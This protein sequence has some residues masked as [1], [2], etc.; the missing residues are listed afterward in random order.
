M[1]KIICPFL[2]IVLLLKLFI[3]K[4]ENISKIL[5]KYFILCFINH[6]LCLIILYNVLPKLSLFKIMLHPI[7]YLLFS[8]GIGLL[9]ALIY[10]IPNIKIKVEP[11]KSKKEQKSKKIRI[12]FHI[13][14][15]IIFSLIIIGTSYIKIF[16]GNETIDE[17]IFYLNNGAGNGDMGIYWLVIKTCF[18]FFL[19]LLFIMISL[20]YNIL[21]NYK[22]ILYTKKRGFKIYPI[23]FLRNHKIISTTFFCML[24]LIIAFFNLNLNNYYK[25]ALTKSTFIEEHYIMNP[26][27]VVFQEKRNLIFIIVESLET[28]MFTKEQGG[29][30]NY[31]IIPELY[32]L[33]NEEGSIYFS[34]TENTGGMSSQSAGSWTTAAIVSSSTGLPFKVPMNRNGYHSDNFMNGAYAVGDLLKENGYYNEVISAATTDFGG[35]QEFYTKHGNYS[36]VDL[37][38]LEKYGF[39]HTDSDIGPWGFNDRYLFEIAKKRLEKVSQKE[40]PFNMTLI[41]IDTHPNDGFIGDYSVDDYDVQYE[42]VYATDSKLIYDFVSWVKQQDFYKNTTIVIVGDH[43]NMQTKFFKGRNKNRYIYNVIINSAVTTNNTKNRIFTAVDMYPTTVAAIGGTI[44]ENQLGIGVNL[45]SDKQTLAEKY[46][47][48]EFNAQLEKRSSFYNTYILGKDFLK[49]QLE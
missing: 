25:N 10:N 17:F 21:I 33:L 26:D 38:S 8:L 2:S 14:I 46:G 37:N 20:L 32:D 11:Y 23:E 49:C 34:S 39:S 1:L 16:F 31:E 30:W 15:L 13:F 45:F 35:L 36:I 43:L 24:S 19:L 12:F 40:E 27:D 22:I 47:L 5:I 28:T 7:N 41:T 4:K 48:D 9:M 18:P 29:E 44:K 42:N 6:L 3:T